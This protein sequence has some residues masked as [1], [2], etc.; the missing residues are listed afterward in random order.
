M[1]AVGCDKEYTRY[2]NEHDLLDTSGQPINGRHFRD[3]IF[4]FTF[5]EL[6]L[7]C[8]NLI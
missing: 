6:Q 4:K 2:L 8:S 1:Y 5:L 7:F 3:D